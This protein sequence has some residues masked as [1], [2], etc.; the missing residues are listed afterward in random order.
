MTNGAYI[1]MLFESILSRIV[2]GDFK[3][4]K[5][6]VVNTYLTRV[7]LKYNQLLHT[8]DPKSLSEWI[9]TVKTV[10]LMT[11]REILPNHIYSTTKIRNIIRMEGVFYR[12]SN[13][14]LKTPEK[15]NILLTE[16]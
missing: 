4:Y 10:A 11:F 5:K 16:E 14:L 2:S 1:I 9:Q 3:Q 13:N 8:N 7:E 6:L 12:L 15:E